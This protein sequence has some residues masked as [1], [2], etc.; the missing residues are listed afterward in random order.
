MNGDE[1]QLTP[2]ETERLKGLSLKV[3]RTEIALQRAKLDLQEAI[4]DILEAHDAIGMGVTAELNKIVRTG[5]PIRGG[6]VER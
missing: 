4:G 6:R 5:G 3:S 2:E 1:I